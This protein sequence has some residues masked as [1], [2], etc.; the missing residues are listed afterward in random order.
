MPNKVNTFRDLKVW[1]KAHDLVL[2]IYKDTKLFP[3]DEKF[4]L[5]SQIR[6]SA[7]SIP[8][9]IAEGFKRNSRKDYL[10]F[11]NVAETSLEETKYHLILSR[12]L[13][14]LESDKYD[15]L[16]NQ[17]EEIGRMLNSLQKVLLVRG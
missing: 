5:I 12:D 9:N 6:R 4:G 10:H 11:L 16:N 7:G 1:A 15:L 17:C 14:Y 8:S 3:D 13:N 2:A